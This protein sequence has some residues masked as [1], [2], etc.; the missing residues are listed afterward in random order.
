MFLGIDFQGIA[1]FIGHE[2]SRLMMS[3]ASAAS[4]DLLVSKPGLWARN[5]LIHWAAGFVAYFGKVYFPKTILP[6]NLFFF[7]YVLLQIVQLWSPGALWLL[8]VDGLCDVL[9]VTCGYC[10]AWM[11]ALRD[12]PRGRT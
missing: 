9:I 8:I 7:A 4:V 10:M 2:I 12:L 1:A 5:S 11:I 3:D 6:L